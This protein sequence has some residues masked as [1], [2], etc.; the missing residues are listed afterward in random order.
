M[1]TEPNHKLRDMLRDMGSHVDLLW[2][3]TGPPDTRIAWLSCYQI[4]DGKQRAI[5]IVETFKDGRG[6][7]VLITP[8][9]KSGVK[10]TLDAVIAI[11]F[12]DQ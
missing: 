12:S 8:S 9:K 2:E 7:E 4:E 1:K 6:W 5:I 3:V 11:L 10:D